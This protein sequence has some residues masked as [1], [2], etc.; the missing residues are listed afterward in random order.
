MKKI[1]IYF[2]KKPN[3]KIGDRL[4]YYNR[5]CVGVYFDWKYGIWFIEC[6][7][8]SISWALEQFYRKRNNNQV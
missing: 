1:F 5:T 4:S 6:E 8:V 3:V 2:F 7:D